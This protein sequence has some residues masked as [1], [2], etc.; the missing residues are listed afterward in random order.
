MI[1]SLAVLSLLVWL[2]LLAGRGRFWLMRE[3]DDRDA[4]P[5]PLVWPS[6]VAIVPARNEADVIACSISSLLHQDYPGAFSVILVDDQSTDDTAKTAQE[7]AA[8][9]GGYGQLQ[10]IAA[11]ERSSGWL[12]KTWA[13]RQG[14]ARARIG[15]PDYIWF[16]D[17]DIAHASDNLR[18][19]VAR[20][21][22][23]RLAMTSQ[24]VMLSCKSF[25]EKLL[26]PAFVF[27]FDMLFP[28]GWVNDH[29]RRI[30]A[31]A[32]GCMLV[33]R[34]VLDAAGGIETIRADIIDDC[35]LA[36]AIKPHGPIWL[37]LTHRAESLRPYGFG[38]IRRMVARTA[39]AQ[40]GFSMPAL[41]A[42]VIGMLIVYVAPPI[43][44]LFG[45]A[46]ASIAALAT[47]ALMAIAFVPISRF[48]RLLP[49]WGVLLPVIGM[50]Y[51]G[52]TI[53]SAVQFWQGKGGFWKGRTQAAAE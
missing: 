5:A 1:L 37:G 32:G 14:F 48:Y 11:G 10:M 2:Y 18:Q 7:A 27:F 24:M 49:F 38:E 15:A 25:W 44:A 3:R 34:V 33:R 17:A 53:D 30:A 35:A 42:T 45:P 6:V 8:V 23:Y 26:I 22:A 50:I 19:L 47:W 29:A 46:T 21:E 40:L 43:L 28:F 12:G 51:A 52:F 16:T 39:Y 20:A 31:A 4:P 9:A 36:R 13:M 41:L